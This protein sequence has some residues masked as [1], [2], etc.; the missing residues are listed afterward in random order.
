MFENILALSFSNPVIAGVLVALG[1][2]FMGW[3]EHAFKDGDITWPEVGQLFATILRMIPQ[4]LALTALG[5][6][7]G[8]EGLGYVSF[9]TDM[10]ITKFAKIADAKE[11]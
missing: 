8:A 4:F 6:A 7:M 1:R 11:K 2:T 10:F 5:S 3:L 9:I